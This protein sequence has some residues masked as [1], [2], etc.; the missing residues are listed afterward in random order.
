MLIEKSSNQPGE[1]F[2]SC[3]L[4]C[5]RAAKNLCCLSMSVMNMTLDCRFG[6]G[7]YWV[8]FSEESI[9]ANADGNVTFWEFARAVAD[10]PVAHTLQNFV[11]RFRGLVKFL[12]PKGDGWPCCRYHPRVAIE[13][14]IRK[15]CL[16][17]KSSM[18]GKLFM[19]I[20][21]YPWVLSGL[22]WQ[23]SIAPICSRFS[24]WLNGDLPVACCAAVLAAV[25]PRSA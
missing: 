3:M 9:D 2:H 22:T 13:N 20:R 14:T 18:D 6:L 5:Q 24:C 16:M 17:G 7:L 12:L 4:E 21:G 19:A 23:W 15:C 10:G 25:L 8:P 1:M 11:T